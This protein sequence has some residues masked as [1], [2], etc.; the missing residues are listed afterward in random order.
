MYRC[1]GAL[2]A[3]SPYSHGR[4]DHA[5]RVVRSLEKIYSSAFA[6]IR[7]KK[8][9]TLVAAMQRQDLRGGNLVSNQLI[10]NDL[11]RKFMQT[12]KISANSSTNVKPT[13]M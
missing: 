6:S 13:L 10:Y 11:Q 5:T 1:K 8:R 12:N 2:D 9:N 4:D 3:P 7:G